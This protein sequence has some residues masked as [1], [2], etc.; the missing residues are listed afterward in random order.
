[1]RR[2]A[3]G[4][5]VAAVSGD[6]RVLVSVLFPVLFLFFFLV[7]VPVPV[8]WLLGE[9]AVEPVEKGLHWG[10]DEKG[11]VRRDDLLS[12]TSSFP[13]VNQPDNKQV[14]QHAQTLPAH[15]TKHVPSLEYTF[16]D[17]T[18]HLA[19]S[20]DG[21]SNGTTLWLGAQILALYLVYHLK[22]PSPQKRLNP[23][24]VE[25]GSGVGLTACVCR[26]FMTCL[27]NCTCG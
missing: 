23:R 24:A 15:E 5:G 26:P 2:R 22:L 14:M 17:H 18:F 21:H 27:L 9:A 12:A 7:L 1:M 16:L 3:D 19:Q 10:R 4:V 6:E 25:L 8:L 11:A 13:G 20:D